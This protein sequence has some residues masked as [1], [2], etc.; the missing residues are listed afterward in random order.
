MKIFNNF[1][2]YEDT[3]Y[4]QSQFSKMLEV[5]RKAGKEVLYNAIRYINNCKEAR[6]L[7]GYVSIQD[8]L[9]KYW[10][11]FKNKNIN[12]L[13]RKG[14]I[15][16]IERFI[17]CKDFAYGYSFYECT[18]CK[19]YHIIGYTCKSR[20][21]PTCGNKYRD[22]RTVKISNKLL[23]VPHRQFV[24]A[25]PVELR[26]HFRVHRE[27][28]SFLF[29]AVN[30][31]FNFLLERSAPIAY[32]NEQREPGIIA[33]IHA[34]GRDLKWHPHIH[35]LVA[36]RF[37]DKDGN[38]RKLSYFYF[39]MIR[40]TFRNILVNKIKSYYKVKYP[41][42]AKEMTTLLNKLVNEH[43]KGFYV[44]GPQLNKEA[45]LKD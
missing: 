4:K 31:T 5:A 43:K 2:F 40:I 26:I 44:Y 38:L 13:Q 9:K 17:K 14:L 39:D 37:S 45:T 34:F 28:L 21:C 3:Y 18:N 33:F 16:S 10:E 36:E 27:M 42:G 12:L 25:I 24:F 29:E 41:K 6:T 15:S 23:D 7:K 30:E 32:K 20:F 1:N 35:A 11:D 8:I 22:E 19:N